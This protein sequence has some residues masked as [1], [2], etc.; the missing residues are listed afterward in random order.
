M[1]DFNE[2]L[3]SGGDDIQS[4]EDYLNRYADRVGEAINGY[5]P[6]GTHPDMDRYLYA[7]LLR[8]SRNGGKRD[9][10]GS[11]EAHAFL[12]I[13]EVLTPPKAKLLIMTNSASEDLPSPVM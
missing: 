3:I 4:F 2:L 9:A 6:K 13:S 11:P 5:I 8:F 7:P 1:I 10:R 12:R